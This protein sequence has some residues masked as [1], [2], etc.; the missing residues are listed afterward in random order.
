VPAST[1]PLPSGLRRTH[2]CEPRWPPRRRPKPARRA[3]K[4]HRCCPRE[5]KSPT[6][7]Y[8]R[9]RNPRGAGRNPEPHAQLVAFEATARRSAPR[10]NCM[11]SYQ[12]GRMVNYPGCRPDP[13]ADSRRR[14]RSAAARSCSAD[15]AGPKPRSQ[16]RHCGS[17]LQSGKV[18]QRRTRQHGR[19]GSHI[20][21][22]TDLPA[23]SP[24]P[25]FRRRQRRAKSVSDGLRGP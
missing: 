22:G 16:L 2:P 6:E 24:E 9:D 18:G 12:P 3:M 23:S 25:A 4:D 20:G 21:A 1:L 19:G 8:A 11:M 5:S 10:T 17:A 15:S 13:A 14:G 7:S